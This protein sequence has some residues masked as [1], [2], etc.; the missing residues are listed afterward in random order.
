M[1]MVDNDFNPCDFIA[2]L[3]LVGFIYYVIHSA[4]FDEWK[5]FLKPPPRRGGG[6]ICSLIIYKYYYNN[7]MYSSIVRLSSDNIPKLS[8][9]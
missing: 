5:L 6:F 7:I 9:I 8:S 3:S 4:L 2:I 1:E